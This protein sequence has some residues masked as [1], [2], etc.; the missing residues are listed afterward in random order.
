MEKC[1]R[2]RSLKALKSAFVCLFEE[3][4]HFPPFS[5]RRMSGLRDSAKTFSSSSFGQLNLLRRLREI[6]AA[7]NPVTWLAAN[8]AERRA[9]SSCLMTNWRE[10]WRHGWWP[11]DH[12]WVG[13]KCVL[14]CSRTAEW[15][16]TSQTGHLLSGVRTRCW[17][18]SGDS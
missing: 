2:F 5:G 6:C 18:W 4:F 12:F 13:S 16:A 1:R 10:W 3:F 14:S 11:C 15:V 7:R 8:Q 9:D 17:R